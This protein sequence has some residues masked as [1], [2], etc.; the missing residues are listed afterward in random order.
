MQNCEEKKVYE[1]DFPYIRRGFSLF[2]ILTLLSPHFCD[3][4]YKTINNYLV[5]L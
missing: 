3:G 4:G 2:F 5:V 1:K